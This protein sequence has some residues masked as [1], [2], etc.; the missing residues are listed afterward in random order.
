MWIREDKSRDIAC[1]VFGLAF[2]LTDEKLD[3]DGCQ[4][5]RCAWWDWA[6]GPPKPGRPRWGYC[7]HCNV[8]LRPPPDN[9][10]EERKL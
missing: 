2:F 3:D 4:G 5:A 9:D 7:S 8:P 6:P 1:P 10:P